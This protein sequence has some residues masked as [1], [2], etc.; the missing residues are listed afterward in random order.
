[1]AAVDQGGV[2]PTLIWPR[3][4]RDRENQQPGSKPSF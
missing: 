3:H 2:M 1:M 4:C